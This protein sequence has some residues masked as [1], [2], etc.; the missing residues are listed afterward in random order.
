MRVLL[1]IMFCFIS[2]T[3]SLAASATDSLFQQLENA[4]GNREAITKE[5]IS[6]INHLRDLAAKTPYNN[7]F[8][9]YQQL[10]QEYK[11]FIYDSAFTYARKLQMLA[12]HLHDTPKISQA[13]IQLGFV[14]VSSGLF[15]EAIDTLKTIHARPLPESLRADFYYLMARTY[16]DLCDFNR[17]DFYSRQ[18][19][20]MGHSYMDSAMALLNP[21]S[22]KFLLYSGIKNVRL[23]HVDVAREAFERMMKNFQLDDRDLAIAAS[24]LSFIYQYTD[25][26]QR[27]KDMLIVAA[28]ADIHASTK[29][30]LAMLN[31]ADI[32]YK[33]GDIERAYQYVK[34]AMDDANFYGA[35]HRKV[36]VAAVFPIIEGQRLRTLESQRK[37]LILY[38]SVI[39]ILTI[40]TITFA[41]ISYKQFQKIQAAK[42]IISE[43]NDSLQ[44]TNHLLMDANKI[45][46]E[47]IWYYFMATADHIT[48][49]DALKKSLEIKLLTK[50]LEDIRFI[51]DSINIKREREELYNNFDKVFL[52]LFPD[53]VTAFNSLFKPEDQ[54]HLK[55]DQLLNTELRIFALIRMG[56]HDNEKIARILDYSVTTIYTYKTRLRNKSTVA[57]DEFDRQIMGI[58]AI[59]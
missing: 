35:R 50:K 31:L 13:K 5:K 45:K 32:L 18:Y 8:D 59:G 6:R 54:V 47:Y 34:I 22:E 12:Y 52:K 15:K 2:V 39:T 17:D 28:I 1:A 10:Y 7:R 14:Q 41:V 3:F 38:A 16:Y 9:L 4:I 24:T 55:E 44:H 46:E 57:N 43:A 37:A 53:F 19:T 36:Q 42:K 23:R 51:V 40:L 56:I 11:S 21:S 25:Q 48:K 49:L 26:P 58:R 33:E 20:T 29:E 30:T 27:A